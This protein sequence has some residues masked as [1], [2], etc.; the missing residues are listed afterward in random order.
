MRIS[1]RPCRCVLIGV[2]TPGDLICDPKRTPFNIGRRV[3]LTDF[4][5]EEALPLAPGLEL[6]E[7]KAREVLEQVIYW[8]GGHPYLT[9]RLYAELASRS[10]GTT[11]WTATSIDRVVEAG[12]RGFRRSKAVVVPGLLNKLGVFSVRLAPRAM[13][14]RVVAWLQR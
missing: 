9:Q 4:T 13:T 6:P 14:R 8:T 2:A 3:D 5:V 10:T 11:Q 7:D 12:Y 1:W